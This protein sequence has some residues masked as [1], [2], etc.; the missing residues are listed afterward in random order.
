MFTIVSMTLCNGE[1]TS[2]M[3]VELFGFSDSDVNEV[4]T[5]RVSPEALDIIGVFMFGPNHQVSRLKLCDIAITLCGARL[6]PK[7]SR[8]EWIMG[9]ALALWPTL[10]RGERLSRK[11]TAAHEE[12]E[13]YRQDNSYSSDEEEPHENDPGQ[14]RIQ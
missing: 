2:P 12:I 6:H 8:D 14:C 10:N 5:K 3:T 9:R 1:A 7:R 13:D 4:F 11:Y